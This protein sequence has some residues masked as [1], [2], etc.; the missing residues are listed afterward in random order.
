MKRYGREQVMNA[1]KSGGGKSLHLMEILQILDAPKTAK[2]EIRDR[3]EDLKEL[4]LA[5]ELPGNR[6]KVGPGR[7][8][9]APAPEP[10][11][12]TRPRG[13]AAEP[14]EHRTA[15]SHPAEARGRDS[16]REGA[17]P[18]DRIERDEPRR[19]QRPRASGEPV[20]GWITITPRGFA[21][22]AAEDGGP[23][24]FV[25]V[26]N[27]GRAMHGDRVEVAARRSDRGREGEVV[28]VL[29]R[30]LLRV[31]GTLVRAR[32]ALL[33]ETNDGRLP[34]TFR[35][36]GTLPLGTESGM[37]VVAQITQYP[38]NPGEIPE[39]RVLSVLGPRG[40]A[41]VEIQKILIREGVNEEFPADVVQEALGFPPE[42]PA[43]DIAERED[44]RHL[45]L[46]TI[47]PDDARDHDDAVWAEELKDGFRVVIAIADVSHYV[48]AGS[49]IDREA[50]ARGRGGRSTCRAIPMLP[51]ELSTNLASLVPDEDRLTLAVEVRLGKLG[52]IISHR[53]IEG[54][55]RSPA[56]IT[57]GGVARALGL[58]EEGE[59]Q[60]EAE[61]RLPLLRTLHTISKRL[62]AIRQ[63][64][65][66][67]EFELP[68]AKVLL[69]E[70][71][72]PRDVIRSR[73]NLGL[74]QAYEIVEDLML[75]A[76]EVIAEDLTRRKLPA[77]YRVH[78]QPDPKKVLTFGAVAEAYGHALE[79]DAHESPK[80]LQKI[81]AEIA[82][83]ENA[84]ALGYLLLRA[85]QQ[86]TYDVSNI[87]HFALAAPDYLHFTSPIRRYPD[88]A[89]HRVV[90]ALARG[91]KIDVPKLRETLQR[92]AVQS[93]R[94]ERRAM[95]VEREA[96]NL[97]RCLLVK[98]RVGE[99][100]PGKITSVT[101]YGV[102]VALD[103][104]FVE[105]RIPIERLGEDYYELDRLGIK[106]VG[107]RSGHGFALGD[108]MTV[109]LESVVIE[110]R[111]IVAVPAS[112]P[113][114]RRTRTSERP[115]RGEKPGP[116]SASKSGPRS[117][118]RTDERPAARGGRPQKKQA[119]R[120]RNSDRRT[121]KKR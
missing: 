106:L 48:R 72:E 46:C 36:V 40:S 13:R 100:F 64:R 18:R 8:T 119:P 105:V 22:V 79:E 71:G 73:A 2:D 59:R 70:K 24:V 1:I 51:P 63:R 117:G 57:Y 68:E 109:R 42:V 50:L 88:L 60:P 81:L 99:E 20:S 4:G 104:P 17:E 47:D 108:A 29:E 121:T 96:V 84:H 65:G 58:V 77:I 113:E 21:F 66:A 39:A 5:K 110:K 74:K 62:R 49:A 37:D 38:E 31:A 6:Y 75:L 103:A 44:L 97:Y 98:D 23:D 76:N 35:I 32:R 118:A 55:M 3:I 85:M 14:R 115:R 30:G 95:T 80:K 53:L 112:L 7:R 45:E 102:T 16:A 52:K 114:G 25:A 43:K 111:E 83:T 33:L 10:A 9:A 116:K 27:L 34:P 15:S 89:V 78:G 93:S 91:E 19:E 69:D 120:G 54:V 92:Q 82:G 86:A 107:R 67:L 12:A 90:R 61:K 87:G 26:P 56:R 41:E 28:R 101:E 11:V 94:M